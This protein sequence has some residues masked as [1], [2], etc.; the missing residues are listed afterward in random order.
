M[1]AIRQTR[2]VSPGLRLRQDPQATSNR[3][4]RHNTL[5]GGQTSTVRRRPRPIGLRVCAQGEAVFPV[6][7]GLT[8][9]AAVLAG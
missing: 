5:A 7:V 4:H 1:S 2:L 9:L 8:V 6:A 3:S